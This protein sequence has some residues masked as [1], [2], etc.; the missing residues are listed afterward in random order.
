M[1]D[2]NDGQRRL[3]VDNWH[4][5][6]ELH[7]LMERGEDV[8]HGLSD[9][10]KKNKCIFAGLGKNDLGIEANKPCFKITRNDAGKYGVDYCNYDQKDLNKLAKYALTTIV[11]ESKGRGF[12]SEY[13]HVA[14]MFTDS[15]SQ[16]NDPAGAL[17]N[18]G[19]NRERNPNRQPW[20]FAAGGEKIEL[21][22]GK[23]L[24]RLKSA[25]Q[26]F[27]K[28]V[29]FPA[30]D[31]YNKLLKE[32]MGAELG[33]KIEIYISENMNALGNIN[34][35]DLKNFSDDSITKVYKKVHDINDFDEKKTK[36]DLRKIL[37]S[38]EKYLRSY[39]DR[40]KNNGK[41]SFTNKVAFF[42][43]STVTKIVY[44]IWFAFDYVIFLAKS[45]TLNE[46][47]DKQNVLTYAYVVRNYSLENVLK[48]EKV[49]DKASEIA[50]NA[51]QSFRDKP[52]YASDSPRCMEEIVGFFQNKV[53]INALDK[54]ISSLLLKKEGQEH[55]LTVLN[56]IY[57]DQDNKDKLE[58]IIAFKKDLRELKCGEM[59]KKYCE[60]NTYQDTDLYEVIQ[61]IND[62]NKEVA[63]CQAYYHRV[64]ELIEVGKPKLKTDHHLFNIR[65]IALLII[66]GTNHKK[67]ES[68]A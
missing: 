29:L 32:R 7:D 33:Q 13:N 39:E 23:V 25:P 26:A 53:Y 2:S 1:D 67:A 20:F 14:S 19:R 54:S 66:V 41:L 21:F 4:L 38:T 18:L 63:A 60:G 15:T 50:Q 62:I 48:S 30:T 61:W 43:A 52:Y 36:E 64:N 35:T 16:F 6:K 59:A 40:I 57:L 9:F 22:V 47:T 49:F 58:K 42:V 46:K 31:K 51:Y 8:L 12:D 10:C 56:A 34:D 11:D 5:S 3:I 37:K 55:L 68:T 24:A 28:K 27:C 65:V 45:C 44:Y 17:Q